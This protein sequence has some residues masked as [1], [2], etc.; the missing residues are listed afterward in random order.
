M[1]PKHCIVRN[2]GSYPHLEFDFN[3]LGLT[4][5]SGATGSGKSS[6]C[7]VIPYIC[8]GITS[9]QGAADDVRSWGADEP[10]T[11]TL[12]V[13]TNAGEITITR[14][15]G[16][17]SQN[18]LYF[19]AAEDPDQKVRGRDLN[20]TQKILSAKLGIDADLYLTSSYYAQF[21]ASDEFFTSKPAQR[22]DILEKICDMDLAVKLA[23]RASE[24]RKLTKKE[25]E[26][27]ETAQ[28]KE[29]GKL[30]QLQAQHRS[31]VSL[32][33]HWEVSHEGDVLDGEKAIHEWEAQ[34][35]RETQQAVKRCNAWEQTHAADLKAAE[36]KVTA[37]EDSHN[38][39]LVELTEQS[40]SYTDELETKVG[41][42]IAQAES[43]GAE[44]QALPSYTDA[45]DEVESKRR[46]I[47]QHREV[48]LKLMRKTSE[49]Q[50]EYAA[51][52]KE[53][54][55]LE[56]LPDTCPTCNR[57]GAS[58]HQKSALDAL[59]ERESTLSVQLAEMGIALGDVTAVTNTEAAVNKEYRAALELKEKCGTLTARLREETAA[60]E[61]IAMAPNVYALQLEQ[62]QGQLNP[63]TGSLNAVKAATNP[64]L[65][66]LEEIVLKA[67]PAINALIAIKAQSNP[68]TGQVAKSATDELEA[69]ARASFIK[70]TV[71]VK[72]HRV[73]CLTQVYD[74]SFALRGELLRN[75]V[76]ELERETNSSLVN[77]FDGVFRVKFSL[78]ED[79]LQVEIWKEGYLANFKSLSGGERRQCVLS[80][81]AALRKQALNKAGTDVSIVTL[82]ESF[83]GL[84][85]DLKTKAF[86]LLEDI[87]STCDSVLVI[88]HSESL[89][90]MFASRFQVTKHG[91]ESVIEYERES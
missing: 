86:R 8:W 47:S 15:R 3:D 14:I 18:D 2:F 81:W 87:S 56:A 62:A 19:V 69:Q 23:E 52:I 57:G 27:A 55:R 38:A 89:K 72:L 11:G 63:H 85:D 12:T 34:R 29:Q 25:L 5:I 22:R 67:N 79:K 33:G 74:L 41:L 75:A 40:N 4:L 42:A 36:L 26:A 70:N 76:A 48:H 65:S 83:A 73:A 91:D 30:E 31:L 16:K 21:T 80:L 37:W 68:Y 10:T 9:K 43:T 84:D 17:A 77:Y 45:L 7:D 59:E 24:A 64:L 28:A 82:D 58:G 13:G 49:L 53:R 32:E 71:D 61:R 54:R 51:A 66:S 44:L 78:D 50:V 1:K 35:E 20:D 90:A 6:L 39:R 88:D 46:N 60:I